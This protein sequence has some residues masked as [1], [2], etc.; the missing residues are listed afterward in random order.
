MYEVK[1]VNSMDEFIDTTQIIP[2]LK[3]QMNYIGSPKTNEELMRT[4][5]LAFEQDNAYLLVISDNSHVVGFSFFNICVGMES[6]GKY[7]WLNEMH[8]HKNYRSKG[9]GK[10]LYSEMVKW[11]N[12]NEIIKIMG[13]TDQSDE[14]TKNFYIK[15][16]ATVSS[17]SILSM[18]I[19]K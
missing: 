3:D 2:L 8:I 1:F 17:E 11:C 10:I 13:I 5:Q 9:Y 15:Q 12:E 19:I 14:R 18:D 7:L 4:I 6:A 16:G